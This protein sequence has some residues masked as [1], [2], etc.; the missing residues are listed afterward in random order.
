VGGWGGAGVGDGTGGVAWLTP[1]DVPADLAAP[2]GATVKVHAH[3]VGA[4]I[5]TCTVTAAAD[6]G[7]ASAAWVLKAPDAI[8]YDSAGAQ[9]GTHGA[10]PSWT[11]SDGSMAVGMKVAQVVAPQADAIP[12]LL[13]RITTTS[14]AGAFS[15]ISYVQRLNTVGGQAPASGCDATTAGMDTRASYTADYYFYTGGAA[16]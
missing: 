8:L 1:A 3:A 10:G 2:A 6:G 15:D 14:G 4:Q 12:W 11:S 5:Y 9:I 13:L 16:G 7:A